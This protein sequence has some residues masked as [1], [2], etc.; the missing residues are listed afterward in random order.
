MQSEVCH[1]L[2]C[3]HAQ[4][5]WP[6]VVWGEQHVPKALYFLRLLEACSNCKA[7]NRCRG[8]WYWL[9]SN[10][11]RL[12]SF[13]N[14]KLPV[15]VSF[16][17]RF[18]SDKKYPKLTIFFSDFLPG[19]GPLLHLSTPQPSDTIRVETGVRQGIV[20]YIIQFL[21][22]DQKVCRGESWLR[23]WVQTEC[24]DRVKF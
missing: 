8:P 14:M 7:C 9:L 21:L 4:Q 2:C 6:G 5:S 1:Q 24:S 22:T 11:D 13:R 17:Y 10:T 15:I 23:S 18:K 12:I 16:T 19:A 20:M 3:K